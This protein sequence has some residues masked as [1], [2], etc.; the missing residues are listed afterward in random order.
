MTQKAHKRH[1][2]L[3]VRIEEAVP[4]I[5]R[6]SHQVTLIIQITLNGLD[7]MCL[8]YFSRTDVFFEVAC[9]YFQALMRAA[10]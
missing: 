1:P 10:E 7:L 9:N 5:A 2:A 3:P 6:M 8:R 4:A